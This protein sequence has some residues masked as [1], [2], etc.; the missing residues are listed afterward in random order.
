LMN[1]QVAIGVASSSIRLT[2]T[3][4]GL[5]LNCST[6]VLAQVISGEP[7]SIPRF[8]IRLS[9]YHLFNSKLNFYSANL[10]E[11]TLVVTRYEFNGFIYGYIYI[12]VK[13]NGR[14]I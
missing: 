11:I 14:V 12:K 13:P 9:F 7:F 3:V 2:T 5:K 1:F 8:K 4:A 10:L 6:V